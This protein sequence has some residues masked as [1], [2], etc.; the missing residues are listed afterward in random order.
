MASFMDF[1]LVQFHPIFIL[2]LSGGRGLGVAGRGRVGPGG[3]YR[4]DDDGM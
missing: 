3:V 1:E 2:I 4:R